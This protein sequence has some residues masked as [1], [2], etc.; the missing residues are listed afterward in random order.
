M[1]AA[2]RSDQ[3]ISPVNTYPTKPG[4]ESSATVSTVIEADLEIFLS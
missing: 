4:A 1:G 2:W 3:K